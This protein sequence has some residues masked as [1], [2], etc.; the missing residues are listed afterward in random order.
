MIQNAWNYFKN[1]FLNF[2]WLGLIFILIS[3]YIGE[4]TENHYWLLFSKLIETI[5]IAIFVASLFSFAFESVGFQQRMQEIV[6]K[7][8]LKRT[9]L[10][11]LS[12]EKK[13][14]ALH[15]LLKPTEKEIKKYSNIEDFYHH[16]VDEI[17]NVSQKNVRSNYNISIQAKFDSETGKVFTEGIYSYRLYPSENGYTDIIVGF[18]KDDEH[19]TVDVIVNLPDGE[20]KTF[21]YEDIKEKFSITD[22]SRGTT[23]NI[24]EYC[25]NFSHVDVELRVKE[26][27][28][29]H[30][31]NVF[32]KAEQATDGFKFALY[33][34]DDIT[35]KTYIL[36][37]VGHNYHIDLSDDRK[38]MHLSCHQWI[39]EGSGLSMII[40]KTD[41]IDS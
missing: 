22:F 20:R 16:Y 34:E 32:F 17:L 2:F 13:K 6:E 15:H 18:L 7:I 8:V 9:F 36:F 1:F 31:A 19:S 41:F 40:S 21:M 27:G 12:Q 35:V 3:M 10:S 14:D 30:W 24:D 25:S 38:T 5:G 33:C 29:N 23:I 11:N 4:I 39:N 26:Y 37:D 28:K